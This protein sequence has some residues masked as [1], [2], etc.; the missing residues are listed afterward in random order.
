MTPVIAAAS[1]HT[2]GAGTLILAA[3]IATAVYLAAC[4]IWPFRSCTKC[5]GNG[6]HRSP[7]GRAW[8]TCHPC[9][10]TG[11]KLRIGRRAWSYLA[12]EHDRATRHH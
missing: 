4:V 8:R 9:N 3:L 2:T 5:D 10:G 7:S 12:R 11:G 6:K 1:H